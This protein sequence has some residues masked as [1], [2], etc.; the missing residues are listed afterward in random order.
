MV[1]LIIL[2]ILL[3]LFP[4]AMIVR[5]IVVTKVMG[6][7]LAIAS[8]IAHITIPFTLWRLDLPWLAFSYLVMSSLAWAILPFVGSAGDR[9]ARRRIR[10]EDIERY[11]RKI[12]RDPTHAAAHSALADA[13]FEIE[14]YDEAI[15]AFD[16]AI[17][18]DPDH[19]R[20]DR[21]KRSQA[22]E[23]RTQRERQRSKTSQDSTETPPRRV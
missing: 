3:L 12:R 5:A 14:R 2:T 13:Y 22:I 15:E 11:E 10:N 21:W 19:S 9:N 6:G 4:V 1:P 8:I 17:V 7:L 20:L 16:R 18:L 23:L